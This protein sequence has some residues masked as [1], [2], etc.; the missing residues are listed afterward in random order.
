LSLLLFTGCGSFSIKKNPSRFTNLLFFYVGFLSNS[1]WILSCASSVRRSISFPPL[2]I[3]SRRHSWVYKFLGCCAF[4]SH[5]HI[6]V[7]IDRNWKSR[8]ILLSILFNLI[9]RIS[10]IN[11]NNNHQIFLFSLLY[12]HLL[13]ILIPIT[14]TFF[15]FLSLIH[16]Y[17]RA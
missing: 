11:I 10:C 14:I 15:F 8:A 16:S 2:T 1:H 3:K 12:Y 13:I 4:L 7:H 17:I 6:P 5:T 9:H